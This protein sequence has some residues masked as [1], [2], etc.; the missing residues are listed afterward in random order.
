MAW[1]LSSKYNHIWMVSGRKQTDRLGW[2]KAERFLG[3]KRRL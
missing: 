2:W 1:R 3:F